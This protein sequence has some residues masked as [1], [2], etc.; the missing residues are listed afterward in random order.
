[1]KGKG[2]TT[3]ADSSGYTE[4]LA[5]EIRETGLPLPESKF[6]NISGL[7]ISKS[8]ATRLMTATRYGKRFILKCLKED[9][10]F[11]PVYRTALLKEF[12]IGMTLDHPNIRATIGFEEINGIGPAIILEYV[13]GESLE[14][15]LERKELTTQKAW[16]ILSQLSKAL[17]YIHSKQVIHRDLKPANIM[18]THSGNVVKLIDFSL[19]DSQTFTVI[20]VPAGT[21]SYMAPEQLLPGAKPDVKADIYS[22][23]SIVVEMAAMTADRQLSRIGEKCMETNPEHRPC[24]FSEIHIPSESPSNGIFEGF[25]FAS[26]K[27]THLLLAIIA[28]ASVWIGV[29]IVGRRAA[30]TEADNQEAISSDNNG[31]ITV[32][33]S[34]LW[35]ESGKAD[36]ARSDAMDE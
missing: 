17:E 23:G 7:Y 28:A 22:F 1:M 25:S 10:R 6:D 13:D 29:T 16:S 12:E 2:F 15:L 11:N 34:R 9:F 14:S 21:R 26:R 19:S 32:I 36:P 27:T 30:T 4:D 35:P 5:S 18:V 8:G 3:D 20:K 31:S 24:S 33:D